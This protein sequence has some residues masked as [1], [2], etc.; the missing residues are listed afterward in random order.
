MSI[1]VRASWLFLWKMSTHKIVSWWQSWGFR[2]IVTPPFRISVGW[3]ANRGFLPCQLLHPPH[4]LKYALGPQ[5]T[6]KTPS[7][8]FI[9][10]NAI[11]HP[12][13]H[14]DTNHLRSQEEWVVHARAQ[15]PGPLSPVLAPLF[16]AH[17]LLVKRETLEP[18]TQPHH[19]PAVEPS[20]SHSCP[21]NLFSHL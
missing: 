1:T 3:A 4:L 6:E 14:T 9:S 19:D 13:P 16:C 7:A 2:W 11:P 17:C 8:S 5:G 10:T 18:E 15:R 21:V 20:P 12:T